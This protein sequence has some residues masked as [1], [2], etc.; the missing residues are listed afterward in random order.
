MPPSHHSSSSH[1]SHSSHSHSSHSSHSSYSSHSS[2]SSYSN[3]NPRRTRVNQ[4]KGYKSGLGATKTYYCKTHDY[5]F[6]PINWVDEASDTYYRKGY[7]DE[8]GQYYSNLLLKENDEYTT[9]CECLYCGSS[10]KLKWKEGA[11]PSCPNCGATL[12]EIT[13]NSAVDYIQKSSGVNGGIG[14]SGCSGVLV[15]VIIGY[16]LLQILI[17]PVAM[18]ESKS[19]LEEFS[20]KYESEKVE[21]NSNI[22]LY[23]RDF[24]VEVL[25]RTVHWMDE[26]ESYYDKETDCYFY[27]N[28][29]VDPYVWQY[30]Y[31]G[32]SSDYGDYG[33]MEYELD[34]DKWYIEKSYNTWIELPD[35]YDTSS[36]WH[37]EGEQAGD[38]YSEDPDIEKFGY[39]ITSED[40]VRM[41]WDEEKCAYYREDDDCYIWYNTAVEPNLWQYWYE[42][43]SSEYGWL[44]YEDGEWF[45][46][47]DGS[48]NIKLDDVT[49][50][51][52]LWHIDGSIT[53]SK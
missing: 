35:E 29:D 47:G 26:Y 11:L 46:E 18:C 53:G 25:G 16:I 49:D 2:G 22:A 32:I 6:Y 14:G 33:W 24:Y 4:P 8:Q 45:A 43:I 21:E 15:K 37:F 10:I 1:H 9:Q 34:E 13:Q 27:Y 23:G 52:E 20:R 28:T 42:G 48:W 36:L 30:W 44:E 39:Y 5:V 40:G 51:S 38:S 41:D 19:K 3:Y 7:Y 50:T 17:V 12:Q 31:E